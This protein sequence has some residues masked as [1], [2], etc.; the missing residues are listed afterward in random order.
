MTNREQFGEDD[1]IVRYKDLHIEIGE[2]IYCT[3]IDD[4][5]FWDQHLTPGKIYVIEDLDFHF[6]DSICVKS[7]NGRVSMFMPAKFFTNNIK[8]LRK[9]KLE[10][11]EKSK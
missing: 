9:K 7:D 3:N 4:D 5:D 2:K 10:E 1:D 11:I 6:P 8:L